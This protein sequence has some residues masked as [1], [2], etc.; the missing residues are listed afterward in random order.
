MG[1]EIVDHNSVYQEC[2]KNEWRITYLELYHFMHKLKDKNLLKDPKDSKRFE[3]DMIKS[4]ELIQQA[5]HNDFAI[6][7]EDVPRTLYMLTPQIKN[8]ILD[9]SN[10]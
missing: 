5:L 3:K 6:K 8:L 2:H 1:K 4:L 9:S 10:D 7:E